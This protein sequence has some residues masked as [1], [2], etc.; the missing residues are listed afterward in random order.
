LAAATGQTSSVACLVDGQKPSALRKLYVHGQT[1]SWPDTYVPALLK[2]E[3]EA[4]PAVED[5]TLTVDK[6]LGPQVFTFHVSGSVTGPDGSGRSDLD[7]TSASGRVRVLSADWY[8]QAPRFTG[9]L[10]PGFEVR[11]TTQF[12]GSDVVTSGGAWRWVEVANGLADGPHTLRLE[13]RSGTREGFPYLLV[14]HPAGSEAGGAP[15]QLVRYLHRESQILVRWPVQPGSLG[16]ASTDL[17]AWQAVDA[18]AIQFGRGQVE[19]GLQGAR[20]FFA[21]RPEPAPGGA[22]LGGHGV[23]GRL[24]VWPLPP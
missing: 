8:W 20:R 1:S 4:V 18:P 7:F 5:W 24:T 19:V 13:L 16:S 2:V 12:F 14:Y 9:Q 10:W 21:V 22:I 15:D 11:W 3:S 6:I 17:E 23:L